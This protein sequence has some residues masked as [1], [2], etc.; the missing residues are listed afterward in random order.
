LQALIA[1]GLASA[2]K[3]RVDAAI[4][5]QEGSADDLIERLVAEGWTLDPGEEHIGGKRVRTLRVPTTQRKEHE[6]TT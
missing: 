5:Q 3:E 1:A 4:V 2:L 6:P